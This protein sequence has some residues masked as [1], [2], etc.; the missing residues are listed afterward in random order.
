MVVSHVIVA[1][2]TTVIVWLVVL[3]AISLF[4]AK[5]KSDDYVS[6]AIL[7]GGSW[8]LNSPDGL[9]NAPGLPEGFALVA[10]PDNKVLHS[11]GDTSCRA[12]RVLNECAPEV[13][14]SP[15]GNRFLSIKGERWSEVVLPTRNGERVIVR[16]GPARSELALYL[17]FFGILNG[18][19]PFVT[20]VSITTAV[21]AIPVGLL[22]AWLFVRPVTRR[23]LRIAK[24]SQQFAAGN[25]ATRVQDKHGDEVGQMARQFDGMADTLEQNVGVLRELAQRNADLTRQ[26]EEAAIQAERVRLSRDLHDDIAQRMFSLSVSTATLPAAIERDQTQAVAQA[27]AIAALAEQTLLQLRALLVELRPSQVLQ[28]GM[29]EALQILCSEWSATYN[30]PVDC[31]IMLTGQRIPAGV[32]DVLYRVAQ[33]SLNNVAKHAQAGSVQVSLVEGRRQITLSTTDDG[34]GFDL[35]SAS[36]S[37]KFGLI[38]MRERAHSLGGSLSV[39]SD[40]AQGTT[41]RLSLPLERD[42]HE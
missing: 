26:A 32:E 29:A 27:E 11:F 4:P 34:R 37:A 25:L 39:E 19:V 22:L 42:E 16:Y 15:F 5:I 40:T 36:S 14:E 2:L 1:S 38:S 17:P 12:G 6:F 24:A 3:L 9:P 33:E 10:G 41:I 13:V 21:L 8:V 23:V 30:I 35:A 31:S 20:A 7:E 28:R 18:N